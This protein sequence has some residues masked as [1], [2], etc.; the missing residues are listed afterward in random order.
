MKKINVIDLD[1]TLI[2]YDSFR[3]YVV[4]KIKSGNIKILIFSV[5]RKLR[6]LSLSEFKRRVVLQTNFF[7]NSKDIDKISSNI[8][9]SI[10]SEVID[11]VKDNTDKDTINVLCSAS[12]DIYVKKVAEQFGWVGFGSFFNK[13]EFYH[14][15]G[16]NKLRFIE[17][18]YPSNKYIYNFAISDSESD[19]KLL[20]QFKKYELV[21]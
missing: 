18:N 16:E 6:L 5:L 21:K 4:E 8:L 11:I 20:K 17:S 9:N 2:P 1:K 3:Y 7:N 14:M 15:W 13:E 10:N 12:P 19:L